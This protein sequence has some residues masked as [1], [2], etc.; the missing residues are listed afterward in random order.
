[1]S[2][3]R[4]KTREAINRALLASAPRESRDRKV[5]RSD[6]VVT[7][8]LM[9]EPSDSSLLW[10]AVRVPAWLLKAADALVDDLEGRSH[11]LGEE[12][13]VRS[14]MPASDRSGHDIVFSRSSRPARTWP[15]PVG[16]RRSY[17]E[18]RTRS[19]PH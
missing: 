11:R 12:V 4:V 6:S 5:V 7:A 17:S 8:A 18:R 9:H 15:T 13:G 19:P 16:P 14:N 1:M 10:D 3:I 2:A